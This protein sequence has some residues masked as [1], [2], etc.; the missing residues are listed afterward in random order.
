MLLAFLI[1]FIFSLAKAQ[2][3]KRIFLRCAFASLPEVFLLLNKE[4]GVQVSPDSYR[5]NQSQIVATL[6]AT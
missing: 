5:D 4:Q 1:L 6:P 2:P 3:N